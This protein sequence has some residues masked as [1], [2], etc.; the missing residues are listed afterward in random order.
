M[1]TEQLLTLGKSIMEGLDTW[2]KANLLTL[3]TDKS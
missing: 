1:N 3:N 2:F